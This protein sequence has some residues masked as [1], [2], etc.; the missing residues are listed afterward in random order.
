ME[1]FTPSR[2]QNIGLTVTMLSLT[3][4]TIKN[5]NIPIKIPIP[6]EYSL[7]LLFILGFKYTFIDLIIAIEKII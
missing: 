6:S 7:V 1:K 4:D 3:N 5:S 2:I